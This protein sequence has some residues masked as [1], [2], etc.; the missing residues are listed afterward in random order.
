MRV[1]SNYKTPGSEAGRRPKDFYPQT[2]R[3]PPCPGNIKYESTHPARLT[4]ILADGVLSWS[5]AVEFGSACVPR[6]VFG[7]AP[8]TFKP[9]TSHRNWDQTGIRQIA[10]QTL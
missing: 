4:V 5:H 2:P 10:W 8:K 7:V 1:D 9:Q 6:A 3:P